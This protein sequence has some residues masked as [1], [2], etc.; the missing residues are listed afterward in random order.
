MVKYREIVRVFDSLKQYKKESL[1]ES[2]FQIYKL[3]IYR[4]VR[5]ILFKNVYH[6]VKLIENGKRK[7]LMQDLTEQDATKALNFLKEKVKT[8]KK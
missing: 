7:K 8:S 6:S 1:W 3:L 5:L 2:F 4:L